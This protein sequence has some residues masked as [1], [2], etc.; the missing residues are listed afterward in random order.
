MTYVKNISNWPDP[1]RQKMDMTQNR[2][3]L[4]HKGNFP[5]KPINNETTQ[6]CLKY[7][8]NT[9][10]LSTLRTYVKNIS[11]W[12]DPGGKKVDMTQNRSLLRH[13]GNSWKI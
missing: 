2:S 8:L 3:L 4:R 12:P 7:N 6:I 1:G 13:K 10:L 9:S 11:N 5:G